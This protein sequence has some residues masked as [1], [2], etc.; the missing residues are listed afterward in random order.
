MKNFIW[1][2]VG[3]VGLYFLSRYNFSQ[4]INFVLNRIGVKGSFF[5]PT[6][7]LS[8]GLQNPTNQRATFKSLSGSLYV[9]E[10][11]VA[12]VSSFG[13]QTISAN[14]ESNILINTRPSATGVF[15]TVK[16]LISGGINAGYIVT[17]TG[18][19]NID[20]ISYPVNITKQF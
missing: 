4:R 7:E 2:A 14:S 8:I 20:N 16:E 3:A 9:N 10:K 11:Y 5:Q 18:T 17:L 19:A 6:I 12:N 13:D 1:L 15:D